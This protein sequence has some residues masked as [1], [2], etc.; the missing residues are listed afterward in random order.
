LHVADFKGIRADWHYYG[1]GQ[2]AIFHRAGLSLVIP[3]PLSRG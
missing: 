2:D 3:V 1:D